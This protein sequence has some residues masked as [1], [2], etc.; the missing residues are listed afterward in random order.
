MKVFYGLLAA[1]LAFAIGAAIWGAVRLPGAG[2]AMI[3]FAVMAG[4]H[5]ALN[6]PNTARGTFWMRAFAAICLAASSMIWLIPAIR[7]PAS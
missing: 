4:L 1:N 3:A 7:T 2:Q 5:I 6:L